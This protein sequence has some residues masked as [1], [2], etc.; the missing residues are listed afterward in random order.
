[1]STFFFSSFVASILPVQLTYGHYERMH[2][3]F[4]TQLAQMWR[5]ILGVFLTFFTV[6]PREPFA[7]THVIV[8]FVHWQ[9][10][11]VVLTGPASAGCLQKNMHYDTR[12]M[13]HVCCILL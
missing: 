10:L 11:A 2:A 12:F 9:T 5:L 6:F 3:R 8:F 7:D 4:D 13:G 1:M